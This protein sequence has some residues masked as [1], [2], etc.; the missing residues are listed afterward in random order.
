MKIIYYCYG[1]T[2][3]SPIAAALHIGLLPKNKCPT[4][5]EILRL[6]WFDK[7]TTAQRGQLFLVGKD[8]AGNPVYVCGRG[9]EKQGITQA[10]I[11]GLLL[12]EGDPDELL[13]VDTL[14]AVNLFMRVGGYLSRRFNLVRIGRPLVVYGAQ[15][16]FPR[17]VALVEQA[18]E[19]LGLI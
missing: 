13:F 11:S 5:E 8:R 4:K 12:A 17:L 19:Q 1:G 14:P 10:I 15:L 18:Q 6:P 16:A 2:H 7:V 9:R 3:S